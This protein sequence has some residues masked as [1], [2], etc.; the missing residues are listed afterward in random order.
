MATMLKHIT[1]P[2]SL[3]LFVFLA[4]TT[5]NAMLI[6]DMCALCKETKDVNFCLKY[7][8]TDTRILDANGFYDVLVIRDERICFIPLLKI[9]VSLF[10]TKIYY[11]ISK[12]QGQVTNAAKQINKVRQKFDGPVGTERI[13]FCLASYHLASKLF[14]KSWEQAHEDMFAAGAQDSATK[15]AKFMRECEEEWKNGQIQKSPVTFYTTNVVKLLSIIQVVV[16]K[17][18]GVQW[19]EVLELLVM[20]VGVVRVWQILEASESVARVPQRGTSKGHKR[21][22]RDLRGGAQYRYDRLVDLLMLLLERFPKA[23]PVQAQVV[24]PMV[25]VQPRAANVEEL[26][27]YLKMMEL[28]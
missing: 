1:S 17:I 28:L 24:P 26:P 2:L 8:G 3:S 20:N 6:K 21:I 14:Q 15:G 4:F 16:S 5:A 19:F 12:C 27:T 23:V 9:K 7:I 18:S 22:R 10:L 11:Q 13:K 25:G